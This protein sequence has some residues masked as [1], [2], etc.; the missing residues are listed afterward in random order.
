MSEPKIVAPSLLCSNLLNIESEIIPF[1]QESSLWP[2]LDV[3]DGHFVPNLT[4]GPPFIQKMA[5]L[6]ALPLDVHLMV[7][8]PEFYLKELAHQGVHNIT[9]HYEASPE[10]LT[11]IKKGKDHFKSIGLALCPKTPLSVL[12]DEIL[13]S[14][15]LLLIMSVRPGHG[16]QTFLEGTWEKL[17]EGKRRK[18]RL[19]L[20]FQIQIDG[21]VNGNNARALRKGGAT[22][23]VAGSYIFEAPPSQ[24]LERVEDLR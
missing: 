14:L 6:T 24:Y 16:G 11:L 20:S 12:S 18:E 4:F 23:L 5:S 10:P 15:D 7:N 2:H 1:E 19:G 13:E 3:M 17:A 9:F 8:N 21:G 22:N